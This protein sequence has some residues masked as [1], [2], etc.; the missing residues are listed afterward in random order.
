MS[1]MISSHSMTPGTPVAPT[2][3]SAN[4]AVEN[5]SGTTSAAVSSGSPVSGDLIIL[6]M[7]HGKNLVSGTSITWPSGFTQ[8]GRSQPAGC[9]ASGAW[10]WKIAGGS[11]PST[12]TVT[13]STGNTRSVLSCVVVKDHNGLDTASV[14][15]LN[16]NTNSNQT[17][18][19]TATTA[20][21]LRLYFYSGGWG[22]GTLTVTPATTS[23]ASNLVLSGAMTS[24]GT[25]ADGA[26]SYVISKEELTTTLAAINHTISWTLNG[27]GMHY[28]SFTIPIKRL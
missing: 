16:S 7:A 25:N 2:V 22:G 12:Y 13:W 8:G 6:Y 21:C 20:P 14:N 18:A 19:T 26:G 4:R 23:P 11:E 27:S 15:S 10:A 9:R 24:S 28:T 17:G 5:T 3:R 1:M